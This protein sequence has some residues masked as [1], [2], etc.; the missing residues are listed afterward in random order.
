[1]AVRQV[2]GEDDTGAYS[3][4]AALL[5]DS[6]L[7]IAHVA[8]LH[9]DMIARLDSREKIEIDA[10]RVN[11]ID[12]AVMQLLIVLKISA[13]KAGKEVVIDFP[14]ENFIEA[15]ELLGLAEML[16]VDQAAAGFF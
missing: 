16:D 15:A 11:S 4:Q 8:A 9:Q 2:D 10:S 1:M 14:S 5:L 6:T 3:E 7:T 13:L 12:T